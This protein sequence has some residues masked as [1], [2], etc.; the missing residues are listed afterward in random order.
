[1]ARG[2]LAIGLAVVGAVVAAEAAVLIL[3][4]REGLVDPAQVKAEA[5]FSP[6]E[7]ERARA[8]R[9]PQAALG[10]GIL[11]VEVGVLALFVARPPR[12]LTATRARPVLAAAGAGAALSVAVALAPLPLQLVARERAKDVGLV[13]QSLAGYARDLGISLGIGGA[14]GGVGAA[15]AVAGMRRLP[16][17]WW[18]PGAAVVVAYGGATVLLWPVVVDPLFN[19]YTELRD[20]RTRDDVLELA[21]RA[22]VDVGKVLVVDASRRTTAVNAAVAGLGATKRVVLYDNLVGDFPPEETRL[23]VAHELAHVRYADLRGGLLFLALVAL[24]GALA[25][26]VVTRRMSPGP[27]GPHTVPALALAVVLI[28]TPVTWVSNQLSR[29]VEARADAY[30]LSLT[31]QPQTFIEFERRIA[32]RN[33]ADPDPP[34]WR[35]GFLR[36]TH[37][38]TMERIGIGVA[39]SEAR[40]RPAPGGR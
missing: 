38:S 1:M 4:P 7:L 13:T 8:F 37:P 31:D 28:S 23:V 18:V 10:W 9:G 27:A 17:S 21:R 3:R 2:R 15:V 33:V 19:R 11:A 39:F 26:A 40:R 22:G 35:G 34:W 30:S 6:Q 32:L 5:Y 25:I 29:D 36:A 24:P 14:I 20:G 16:R 12:V